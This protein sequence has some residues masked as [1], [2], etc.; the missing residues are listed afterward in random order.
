M[1][2]ELRLGT[3]MGRWCD[4]QSMPET[5]RRK[6]KKPMVRANLRSTPSRPSRGLEGAFMN[7][8]LA[9]FRIVAAAYAEAGNGEKSLSETRILCS[10]SWERFIEENVPTGDG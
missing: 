2:R 9:M 7:R 8:W 6:P 4:S 1:V 5:S 3:A 10:D